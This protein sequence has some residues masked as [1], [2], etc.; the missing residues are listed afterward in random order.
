MQDSLAVSCKVKRTLTI[1]PRNT[2]PSYLP[3]VNENICPFWHMCIAALWIMAP[4]WKQHKRPSGEWINKCWYVHSMESYSRQKRAIC[5]D[6]QQCG[7]ISENMTLS[8][9]SQTQ[10]ETYCT[11]PHRWNSKNKLLY[12]DRK[13]ISAHL[14]PRVSLRGADWERHKGTFQ[15]DD[16]GA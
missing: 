8:K 13:Q 10:K 1:W 7:W 6:T 12:R 5:W 2:T 4:S 3:K 15:G 16:G 9:R 14:K 11:T